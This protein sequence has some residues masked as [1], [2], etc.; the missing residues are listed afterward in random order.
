[1]NYSQQQP[2]SRYYRA[3]VNGIKHEGSD[4]TVGPGIGSR[5]YSG[6]LRTNIVPAESSPRAIQ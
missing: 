5:W 4:Q 2:N 1:M 3:R 6:I